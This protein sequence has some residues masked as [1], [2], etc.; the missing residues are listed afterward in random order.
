MRVDDGIRFNLNHSDNQLAGSWISIFRSVD[1]YKRFIGAYSLGFKCQV[2]IDFI[3]I[4]IMLSYRPIGVCR[5]GWLAISLAPDRITT[6]V[7]SR[8]SDRRT[9]SNYWR[10]RRLH[11]AVTV[12]AATT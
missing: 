7:A 5:D 3:I 10:R 6:S 12:T 2:W 1:F 8:Q 9:S 4:I 11:L